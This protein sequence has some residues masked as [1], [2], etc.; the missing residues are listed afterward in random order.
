MC[1]NPYQTTKLYP[2]SKYAQRQYKR[3]MVLNIVGKEENAGY[4]HFLLFQQYF[5]KPSFPRSL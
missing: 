2:I 3:T 1:F 4:Q 5:E